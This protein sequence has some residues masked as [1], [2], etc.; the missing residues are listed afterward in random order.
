M[1]RESDRTMSSKA[2]HKLAVYLRH[3]F[4]SLVP[5]LFWQYQRRLMLN[6][7]TQLPR[8]QQA[9]IQRRVAYYNRLQQPFRPS[10][11]AEA[12][13]QFRSSGKSTAYCIDFCS[14]IRCFPRNRK[15]DYQFGDITKVPDQP[16]FVKSRPIRAN[17][18]NKNSVLLKLNSIRHYHFVP[19]R[20]AF[21][22]KK[23]M[24]VWRGK[25]N[26]PHRIEFASWFADHPQCDI[27][28]TRHKENGPAPYLKPFMSIQ[29]QLEYQFVVSVEGIDVA[30]NLKWIMASNSLCMM[31]RPRYETWFME[32][33][34]VPGYHYVEL[35][36]DHSDLPE[37]IEYY[38]RHPDEALEIIANAQR[39]VARF[40]NE[41]IERITA[42][43][44]MQKYLD[45]SHQPAGQSIA[46][47]PG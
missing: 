28:C 40:Q 43:M 21:A 9:E 19:D 15:V 31:R 5:R 2:V 32:G 37:K 16:Q 45:L 17:N 47:Q 4:R 44:V 27:G 13:G 30:T 12:V 29:E 8:P 10:S 22:E 34:L 23:P 24:A 39:H 14:L 20:R 42:L 46:L 38:T 41:R 18:S 7:F 33:S 26:R 1:N 6:S 11:K 25:S 35:A 36:D 3:A